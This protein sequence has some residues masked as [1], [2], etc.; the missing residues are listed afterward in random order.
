MYRHDPGGVKNDID[1]VKYLLTQPG[2]GSLVSNVPRSVMR[3]VAVTG[4]LDLIKLVIE[5]PTNT[6]VWRHGEECFVRAMFA[7]ANQLE[8]IKCVV[9]CNGVN[10]HIFTVEWV[11][12]EASS[13]G[14][15]DIVK[16]LCFKFPE[17]RV[18]SSAKIAIENGHLDVLRFF[19]QYRPEVFDDEKI[20]T[21][22]VMHNNVE[23][24]HWVLTRLGRDKMEVVRQALGLALERKCTKISELLGNE[25][26]A[27][28]GEVNYFILQA[29]R[30]TPLCND[31]ADIVYS[32]LFNSVCPEVQDHFLYAVINK[33]KM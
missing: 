32:F 21:K 25:L 8:I 7:R 20:L 10:L 3:R 11:L 33:I 6:A 24:V 28:C 4:N 26:R 23:I 1:L 16:F 19:V 5:H 31:A 9:A 14:C 22:A 17:V 18:K 29:L 30:E 27:R 13:K 2:L 12:W 15:L